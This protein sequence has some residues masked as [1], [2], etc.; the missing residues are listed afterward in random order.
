MT[1]LPPLTRRVD[2]A[3]VEITTDGTTHVY[4]LVH[5]DKQPIEFTAE[6]VTDDV[7][8]PRDPTGAFLEARPGPTRATIQVSGLLAPKDAA[9]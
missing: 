1:S 4:D 3:R 2:H 8:D 5:D 9:R 6:T 7:Y